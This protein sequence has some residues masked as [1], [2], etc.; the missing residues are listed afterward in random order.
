MNEPWW[1][2]GLIERRHAYEIYRSASVFVDIY[3][4]HG[5]D[6]YRTAQNRTREFADYARWTCWN[7]TASLSLQSKVPIKPPY[8]QRILT[9]RSVVHNEFGKYRQIN[10]AYRRGYG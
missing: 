9:E 8:H 2:Q 10:A 4:Q 6:Y 7:F 5:I 1:T 3:C